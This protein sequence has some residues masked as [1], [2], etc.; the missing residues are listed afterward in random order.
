MS[1]M[2]PEINKDTVL[3]CSGKSVRISVN[4]FM[5]KNE[6]GMCIMGQIWPLRSQKLKVTFH[7]FHPIGLLEEWFKCKSLAFI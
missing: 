1:C 7:Q 4:I 5:Q 3:F 2:W 6:R